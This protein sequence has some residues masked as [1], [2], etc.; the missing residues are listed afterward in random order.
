MHKFTAILITA[1]FWQFLADF[2]PILAAPRRLAASTLRA[3]VLPDAD[4]PPDCGATSWAALLFWQPLVLFRPNRPATILDR[5][6][7]ARLWAR[8]PITA[9]AAPSPLR[10]IFSPLA[11]LN[12]PLPYAERNELSGA[13][14]MGNAARP[15]QRPGVHQI[16]PRRNRN[17][18]ARPGFP[19]AGR[20]PWERTNCVMRS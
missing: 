10:R 6:F 2:T 9:A 18:V 20:R 3:S 11:P 13:A 16:R 1:E 4:S 17:A 8:K 14:A 19:R 7:Q 5:A 12:S 15:H